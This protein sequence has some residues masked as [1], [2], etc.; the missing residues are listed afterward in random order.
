LW[1]EIFDWNNLIYTYDVLANVW[2]H[3]V[4]RDLNKAYTILTE[5]L[6]NTDPRQI[7]LWHFVKAIS[8]QKI[9]NILDKS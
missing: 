9:S 6:A 3:G 8:D 7:K 5:N 4:K 2:G 1:E